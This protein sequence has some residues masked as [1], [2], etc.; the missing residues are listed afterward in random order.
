M[1]ALCYHIS[2]RTRRR[3]AQAALPSVADDDLRPHADDPI[4]GNRGM[5]VHLRLAGAAAAVRA[6]AEAL[7]QP[8][9][10]G[11]QAGDPQ[12]IRLQL[13]ANVVYA[14]EPRARLGH[15]L[16]AQELRETHQDP[17]SF[18]TSRAQRGSPRFRR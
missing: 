7:E 10:A 12:P 18:P 14:A 4:P 9:A 17:G 6:D 15:D 3:R 1:L 8:E 2:S 16:P 5:A 11:T 13:P